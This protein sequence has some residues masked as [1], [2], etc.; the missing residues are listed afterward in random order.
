[1]SYHKSMNKVSL[2]AFMVC[3]MLGACSH[4]D[5]IF[6]PLSEGEEQ[7]EGKAFLTLSLFL[8]Q[9]HSTRSQTNGQGNTGTEEE[10]L[11]KECKVTNALVVLGKMAPGLN[12][13][14]LIERIFKVDRFYYA[15]HPAHWQAT[16]E[17]NPGFYRILVIANA[18]RLFPESQ[19]QS[20]IW[21]Q[22]MQTIIRCNTFEELKNLWKDDYFLMTNA[23]GGQQGEHDVQLLR[24]EHVYKSVHVQRA[25]ARMDYQTKNNNNVYSVDCLVDGNPSTLNIRLHGM[26]LMNV[27]N[28][29]HLFKQVVKDNKPGSI[30]SFYRFENERN[31]VFD[32]D[33]KEKKIF[34]Y[35]DV[36]EDWRL[37][38]YFFFPS[39]RKN[40]PTPS[41]P[42]EFIPLP[43]EV[44]GRYV[45][46]AYCS[47]NTIPGIQVQVNKI[48][49]GV[50]FKGTFT[51]AGI[52][53]RILSV[54]QGESIFSGREVFYRFI[55]NRNELFTTRRSLCESLRNEGIELTEHVSDEM[56]ARLGVK[57]FVAGTDGSFPVWFTYWNRHNDNLDNQEM[58]IMEFAVVRNNIYKLWVNRIESLGL[59]QPPDKED[60]PW[61]PDGNTPDEQIPQIDVSVEVSDWVN[62]VLDYEI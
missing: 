18:D 32:S 36:L 61:K 43:T 13:P 62:R 45:P 5:S 60:N 4:S 1:M 44:N 12:E 8:P 15:G 24:G 35:S 47:E 58:G 11:P 48:S 27:S 28:N 50:V 41:L 31:Y 16:L 55:R 33:W 57:R 26:A 6:S 49:T 34:L 51:C 53:A 10:S 42:L 17:C 40:A 21:S 37:R 30:P 38:D 52:D 25:C 14:L 23:Y 3:F 56:L 46:M 54:S 7:R 59:P 2:I 20:R 9:V 29:F 22:L 19:I 39:E